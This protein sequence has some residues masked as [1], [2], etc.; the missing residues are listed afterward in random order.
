MLQTPHGQREAVAPTV[1]NVQQSYADKPIMPV[2]DGEAAYEMLSDSLPTKWTRQM[3]WLCMTNG[4]AG[5][6]YG[7]NGI[8]QCNRRGQ[9]HGASPHGGNYGKIPW[10][11]AMNLPGS[12]Q[13]GWGKQLF[14][15]Y[16]WQKFVPHPEW[17]SYAAS[18]GAQPP[19]WGDWIWFPEGEPA[20]SAPAAKRYFRTTFEL[21]TRETAPHGTL[22]L[23][24][25]DRFTAYLNGRRLGAHTGTGTSVSFDVSSKLKPGRNVLAVEAENMPAPVSANPAGLLV[26]LRLRSGDGTERSIGSDGTW[27]STKDVS[28]DRKWIAADFNDNGWTPAKDLGKYGCKPWGEFSSTASYGPYSTG[29][30]GKVRIIYVP[31]SKPVRVTHLE[32]DAK[33][34]AMAFDPTNGELSDLGDLG[35]VSL[36]KQSVFVA[37]KPAS[38]HS[39]DWVVVIDKP[40]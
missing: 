35:D 14:E 8:W 22:W 25:D 17:A 13:L 36:N 38:I 6:T 32:P 21:P 23:S 40:E 19:K 3:F 29:I 12:R 16:A 15:R 30:P 7:A 27:L 2:I 5:H 1:S 28:D 18:D 20:T 37:S 39:D 31:E 4:A 24:A 9:P 26:S 34:R 10:D 33:Y 11:E